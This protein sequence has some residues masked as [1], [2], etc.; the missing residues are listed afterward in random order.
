M[1]DPTTDLKY[2]IT[3]DNFETRK[4]EAQILI[5]KYALITNLYDESLVKRKQ[6]ISELCKASWSEDKRQND[7][8]DNSS[9]T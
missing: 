4:S 8:F 7:F 1:L 6:I 3:G 9:I 2:E 5:N